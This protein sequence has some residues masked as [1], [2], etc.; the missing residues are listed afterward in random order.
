MIC[1]QIST[2]FLA[3]FFVSLTLPLSAQDSQTER[4]AKHRLRLAVDDALRKPDGVHQA[5]KLSGGTFYRSQSYTY[6]WVLFR[7]VESLSESCDMAIIGTPVSSESKLINDGREIVTEYQVKVQEPIQ[8]K[9]QW[10]EVVTVALPGGKIAFA[11]G[12]TAQLDVADLPRL[13]IGH[14]YVLYLGLAKP[15]DIY[16]PMGGP[17][18]IFE[19]TS[20]GKVLPFATS[21]Y[22]EAA[23]K[24]D[25]ALEFVEK[26]RAG[27]KFHKPQH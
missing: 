19:L 23:A 12:T 18:G 8:G 9:A 22:T 16:E 4:E 6:G 21:Q 11:D 26:V 27:S 1:K 25:D 24:N 14:R 17:E 2:L 13:Q 15:L 7:T 3:L 20:D 10:D 5:A